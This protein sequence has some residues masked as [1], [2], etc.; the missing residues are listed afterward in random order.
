MPSPYLCEAEA[1]TDKFKIVALV[2]A[3][4]FLALLAGSVTYRV[5]DGPDLV[6]VLGPVHGIIFLVY[7]VLALAIREEQ[8]WTGGQTLLVILAAAIPLGGF[9]V[10]RRLVTDPDVAATR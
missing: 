5:F 3:L 6:G 4:S 10:N 9:I 7:L 8:G 2:E 1:V